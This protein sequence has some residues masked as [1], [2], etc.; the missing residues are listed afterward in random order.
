MLIVPSRISTSPYRRQVVLVFALG[1][2][3]LL[4]WMVRGFLKPLFLAAVFAGIFYPYYQRLLQR[5]GRPWLASFLVVGVVT[6]GIFLAGGLLVVVAARQALEL[7]D[8]VVPRMTE[9]IDDPSVES[10]LEWVERKFPVLAQL[11]PDH[12]IMVRKVGEAGSSATAFVMK[13]VS[14]LTVGAA[15]FLIR[16]FVLIYAM[17]FYLIHGPKILYRIKRVVPLSEASK[18]RIARRFLSV[19]R[20]TL[21]GTI[22]IGVLQGGL[23]GLALAMAG[24]PSPVFLAVL[25]VVLSVIP[26][27]GSALVWVPVV[28]IYYFQGEWL[29][30]TLLLVWCGLIVGSL[31]NL[32]RPKLVGKDTQLPDLLVLIGTLGGIY[33]FGMVGFI[34]GPVICALWITAWEIYVVVFRTNRR[35][36]EE[37]QPTV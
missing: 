25:M 24:V 10:V 2:S 27:I 31:D 6:S 16:F 35:A 7:S 22:L 21:K 5:L 11:M 26:G 32:L 3:V 9:G 18:N 20:A 33:L 15:G 17:Y 23:N 29:V 8:Q 28:A 13:Q 37:L 36:E 1:T 19:T 12:D 4:L 34:L 30:A 14:S